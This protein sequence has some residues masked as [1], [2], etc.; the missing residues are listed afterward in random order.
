MENK[1][2]AYAS[3]EVEDTFPTLPEKT[4]R[5]LELL[6]RRAYLQGAEDNGS[7][8]L[9]EKITVTGELCLFNHTDGM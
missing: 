7:D 6:L 5:L 9:C 3:K 1:A 4:K 2:R 8:V